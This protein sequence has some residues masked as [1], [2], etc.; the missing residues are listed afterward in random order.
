[1][2]VLDEHLNME[3]INNLDLNDIFND[4]I[5]NN[6]L[7]NNIN[8]ENMEN[9]I[10]EL[11]NNNFLPNNEVNNVPDNRNNLA[12]HIDDVEDRQMPKCCVCLSNNVGVAFSCGHV[13][14]CSSCSERLEDCPIC[15]S[16]IVSRQ[17]LFFS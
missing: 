13:C 3:N 16:R 2:N 5:I 12:G 7:I 6:N 11:M 15:R 14:C 10:I 1:M 9:I 8:N 4:N 17:R